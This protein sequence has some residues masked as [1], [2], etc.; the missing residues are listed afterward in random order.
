[1]IAKILYRHSRPY[2]HPSNCHNQYLK[3]VLLEFSDRTK[4]NVTLEYPDIERSEYQINF[5]IDPPM[6]STFLKIKVLSQ[7]AYRN[8]YG[9]IRPENNCKSRYGISYIQMY[10]LYIEGKMNLH[11][12]TPMNSFRLILSS[13]SVNNSSSLS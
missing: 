2:Y 4:I 11:T 10:G 7:Y 12:I 1:M 6:L 9:N 8:A 5:K 3:D 13:L